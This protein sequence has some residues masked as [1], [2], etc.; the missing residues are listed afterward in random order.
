MGSSLEVVGFGD[1]AETY[2]MDVAGHQPIP[3]SGETCPAPGIT[4]KF[5]RQVR[6][7]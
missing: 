2:F 3:S 1:W 5:A 6:N 4:A 7:A